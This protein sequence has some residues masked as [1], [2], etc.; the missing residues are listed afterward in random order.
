MLPA[1]TAVGKCPTK[2]KTNDLL[3]L[4]LRLTS[5]LHKRNKADLCALFLIF[6]FPFN[7]VSFLALG[8]NLYP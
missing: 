3:K 7:R 5:A 6:D 4:N 2:R 8:L 1:K